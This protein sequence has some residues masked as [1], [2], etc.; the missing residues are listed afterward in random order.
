MIFYI[1]LWIKIFQTLHL[2]IKIEIIS[3]NIGNRFLVKLINFL[4][5]FQNM[6]INKIIFS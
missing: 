5:T 3:L 4:N 6:I 1:Y 2:P